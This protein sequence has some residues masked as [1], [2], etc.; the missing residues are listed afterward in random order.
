MKKPATTVIVAG[1]VFSPFFK[2]IVMVH[3]TSKQTNKPGESPD[4]LLILDGESWRGL[5]HRREI[6]RKAF[7][8]DHAVINW[9]MEQDPPLW[10]A[11]LRIDR[12]SIEGCRDLT[13]TVSDRRMSMRMLP[14]VLILTCLSEQAYPIANHWLTISD[15]SRIR[16][17]VSGPIT[18][19]DY[20]EH[21]PQIDYAE[22]APDSM[23]RRAWT[24]GAH[25]LWTT[26]DRPK[27][28][29]IA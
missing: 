6:L 22:T 14:P 5:R 10:T 20:P 19:P 26:F 24:A 11:F 18:G 1:N 28:P 27:E 25:Y 4:S 21:L 9:Y 12:S 2:E 8:V 17:Y 7:R 3:F 13:Y 29:V 23:C 15:V 16:W